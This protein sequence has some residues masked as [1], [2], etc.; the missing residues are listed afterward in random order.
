[1]SEPQLTPEGIESS[2]S[3][4][5][6]EFS[7]RQ[8]P[9]LAV[10]ALAIFGVAYTNFSGHPLQG[11]WEFLAVAMALVSFAAGGQALRTDSRA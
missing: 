2:G 8:A 9:F 10:L 5:R 11:F 6:G 4:A 7:Y 3:V 1:M